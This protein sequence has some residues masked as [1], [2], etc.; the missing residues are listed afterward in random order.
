MNN[1]TIELGDKVKCKY[2]GFMGIATA[3]T[4]FIN[5]CVQ[6]AVAPKVGKD[7]KMHEGYDVDE[8]SI[9]VITKNSSKKKSKKKEQTGG[10]MRKSSPRKCF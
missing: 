6:Y 5:G 3:R 1:K 7:N 2:T 4:E 8:E 9:I 10:A